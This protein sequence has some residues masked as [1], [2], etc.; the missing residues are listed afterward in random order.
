VSEENLAAIR[1]RRKT[2]RRSA[3]AAGN[4]WWAHPAGR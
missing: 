2:W 4:I 1:K 3:S